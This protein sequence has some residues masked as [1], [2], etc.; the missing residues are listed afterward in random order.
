MDKISAKLDWN[1][2]LGFEQVAEDRAALRDGR[3]G[4]KVGGKVGVKVG[5][6]LGVKLGTK[7]GIKG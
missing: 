6:K 5:V 3:V 2:M 7:T 4:A 1:R